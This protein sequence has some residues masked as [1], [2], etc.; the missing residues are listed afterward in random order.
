[1]SSLCFPW[2]CQEIIKQK[3]VF[4]EHLLC[5][6]KQTWLLFLSCNCNRNN[7]WVEGSARLWKLTFMTCTN[8]QNALTCQRTLFFRKQST[9]ELES[10][11]VWVQQKRTYFFPP[12][13][14]LNSWNAKLLQRENG[15][16]WYKP[17]DSS[18]WK[19]GQVNTFH[20]FPAP[21]SQI[22][23][24]EKLSKPIFILQEMFGAIR[25]QRCSKEQSWNSFW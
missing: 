4:L 14:F 8:Y 10:F 9:S 20:M 7:F 1:M 22:D 15:L 2:F 23:Y 5:S 3:T 6:S 11:Y 12:G 24:F 25:Q 18:S 16:L 13:Q 21:V 17:T 19:S